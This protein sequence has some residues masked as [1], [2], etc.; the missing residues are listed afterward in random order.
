[1]LLKEKESDMKLSRIV[2]LCFSI[3]AC[4]TDEKKDEET[5][6]ATLRT[7]INSVS[8]S[9]SLTNVT[10]CI[11]NSEADSFSGDFSGSEGAGTRLD[12]RINGLAG[13]NGTQTCTL[14]GT[15]DTD[16]TGC[17]VMFT[18]PNTEENA[19][20]FD[21]YSNY[22]TLGS[23]DTLEYNG[24]CEITWGKN[25]TTFTGKIDCTNL[26]QTHRQTRARNPLDNS[27]TG[28]LSNTQFSCQY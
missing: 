11:F 27:T 22:D 4:G 6:Y 28:S 13:D 9:Y 10:E 7:S 14:T 1:M 12:V 23:S 21:Q 20:G 15:D 18:V 2:L 24:S 16:P 26:V 3:S 8:A 25:E 19:E 17:N 5:T